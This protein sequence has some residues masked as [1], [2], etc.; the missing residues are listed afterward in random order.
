MFGYGLLGAGWLV[1]K[2]EGELQEWARR[3]GRNVPDRGLDRD[4]RRQHVDAAHAIPNIAQ[5]W[6][7][8]AEHRVAVRRCRSSPRLI[9]L[10]DMA[11]A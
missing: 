11:G 3:H 9:A 10:V 5:R 2:T 7:S 4:R 8:L 6:F 1:L